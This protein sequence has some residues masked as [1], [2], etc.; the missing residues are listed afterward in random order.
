MPNSTFKVENQSSTSKKS[1]GSLGCDLIFSFVE[2]IIH[3]IQTLEGRGLNS[4]EP[5]ERRCQSW[6]AGVRNL[7]VNKQL[8]GRGSI[9]II[10][11]FLSYPMYTYFIKLFS[12]TLDE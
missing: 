1:Y 12:T 5:S 8:G 3:W 6:A 2:N 4:S 7:W 10:L 9:Q 11:K